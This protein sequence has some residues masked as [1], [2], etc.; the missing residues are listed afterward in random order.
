M[1][2]LYLID[3]AQEHSL[4]IET[5]RMILRCPILTKFS[6]LAKQVQLSGQKE[7]R[8]KKDIICYALDRYE[9]LE[10]TKEKGK[11]A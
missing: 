1:Q 5:T 8:G 3:V 2:S 11:E 7:V 10:Q 6:C 9:R 4:S